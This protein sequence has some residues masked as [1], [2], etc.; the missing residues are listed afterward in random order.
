MGNLE[1]RKITVCFRVCFTRRQHVFAFSYFYGNRSIVPIHSVR[2]LSFIL[3]VSLYSGCRKQDP[4][5]EDHVVASQIKIITEPGIQE[6]S[7]AIASQDGGLFLTFLDSLSTHRILKTN[8]ELGKLWSVGLHD[9]N[10]TKIAMLE[11]ADRSLWV[12]GRN[13]METDRLL[14]CHLSASGQI[15]D[16]AEIQIPNTAGALPD[17]PLPTEI[18]MAKNGDVLVAATLQVDGNTLPFLSRLDPNFSLKSFQTFEPDSTLKEAHYRITGLQEVENEQFLVIGDVF[19]FLPNGT[20]MATEFF[21]SVLDKNGQVL[22]SEVFRRAIHNSDLARDD[23]NLS[24][25]HHL[26]PGQAGRFYSMLTPAS[27]SHD[28]R[29]GILQFD[30]SG[31][32]IDSTFFATTDFL[33]FTDVVRKPNGGY[34]LLGSARYPNFGVSINFK[35]EGLILTI[36]ENGVAEQF[37]QPAYVS[38]NSFVACCV[39]ADKRLVVYGDV[40]NPQDRQINLILI[41][42]NEKGYY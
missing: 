40:L 15:L 8:P 11:M 24:R 28:Q 29:C 18:R 31:R 17:N 10:Q 23:R 6:S 41:K 39:L 5:T 33:H 21:S 25:L 16:R 30:N 20:Q 36:S 2:L 32:C 35:K 12:L 13:R 27:K 14:G 34:I 7:Q 22:H 3:M 9:F 37:T 19:S 38:S 4:L 26:F 1:F 42:L